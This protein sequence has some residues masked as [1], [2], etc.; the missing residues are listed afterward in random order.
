MFNRAEARVDLERIAANITHLKAHS[1]TPVMAVVKADA[2]GHG[3]VPVALAIERVGGTYFG[4]AE[5]NEGIALREAGLAAGIV[6]FLGSDYY[7]EIIHYDLSP[8][9][10]DLDNLAG[11]SAALKSVVYLF[12]PA[13]MR[14]EAGQY[15]GDAH[16]AQPAEA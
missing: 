16:P 10:F 1:G 11:L 6:V 14:G 3:L 4:V 9:V 12:G 5:V 15:A 13:S 8:V 7:D 2:Y